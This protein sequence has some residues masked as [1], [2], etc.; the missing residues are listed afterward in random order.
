MCYSLV[1]ADL[2]Q[3]WMETIGN[4]PHL[5]FDFACELLRVSVPPW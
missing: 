1:S 4:M 3:G 5:Q 2:D